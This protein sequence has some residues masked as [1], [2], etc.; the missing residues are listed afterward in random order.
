MARLTEASSRLG[1]VLAI[2]PGR[3][4]EILKLSL[5]D[6]KFR[7]LCEDLEAAQASLA[8]MAA[9]PGPVERPE[10]AEYRTIIAELEDEI[11]AY[12]ASESSKHS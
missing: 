4:Q 2:F 9:L 10:V 5:C 3:T 1:R 8:R 12:L 7:D 11:R 6:P